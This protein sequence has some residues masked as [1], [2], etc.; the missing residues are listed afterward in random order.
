MG[1]ITI[2]GGASGGST[3]VTTP[4]L[5][6]VTVAVVSGLN[7]IVATSPGQKVYVEAYAVTGAGTFTAQ[8][9]SGAVATNL[10]QLSLDAAAGN[11]GA[12]LSTTYPSYL[13]STTAGE[14]LSLNSNANGT[15]S[16]TYWLAS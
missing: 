6:S 14:A 16:V 3:P 4:T 8:F 13:F 7:T 5:L 11:S 15:V 2:Q 12:N 1:N 9:R 10:W